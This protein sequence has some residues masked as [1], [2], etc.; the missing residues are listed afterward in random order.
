MNRFLSMTFRTSLG[1]ILAFI[2]LPLLVV[3][4]A[5]VSPTARIVFSPSLWTTKWYGALMS[6]RWIDPFLLS[7]ELALIVTVLSGLFGLLAAFAVAYEKWLPSASGTGRDHRKGESQSG[8]SLLADPVRGLIDG[9]PGPDQ[10][11]IHQERDW[12]APY[13]LPW[14]HSN[15]ADEDPRLP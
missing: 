9:D 10:E 14:I 13:A 8:R 7:V 12:H 11:A 15:H 1:L 5:S 6:S 3:L 2:T 4:V